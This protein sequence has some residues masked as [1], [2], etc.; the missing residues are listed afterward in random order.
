MDEHSPKGPVCV[1][2]IE[3]SQMCLGLRDRRFLVK[4]YVQDRVAS[5]F[6]HGARLERAGLYTVIA[7]VGSI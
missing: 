3:Q 2:I 7:V 5:S 1:N 6:S 4:Q